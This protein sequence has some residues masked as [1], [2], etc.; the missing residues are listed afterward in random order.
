MLP[1]S[2]Y[3][4]VPVRLTT[5]R[6]P[7]PPFT[8]KDSGLAPPVV[9]LK[10][11][12]IVQVAWPANERPQLLVEVNCPA[13]VPVGAILVTA[14]ALG[15]VFVTVTDIAALDVLIAWLPNASERGDGVSTVPCNRYAANCPVRESVPYARI[16]P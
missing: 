2:V 16:S 8:V 3:V 15:L 5:R 1:S 14:A 7:P 10:V 9:G 4:P 12:L 13:V 6:P 11:T